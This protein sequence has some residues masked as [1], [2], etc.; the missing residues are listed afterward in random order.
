MLPEQSGPP[1]R[2]AC[3]GMRPW[4]LHWNCETHG[5]SMKVARPRGTENELS[6]DLPTHLLFLGDTRIFQRSPAH[7]CRIVSHPHLGRLYKWCDKRQ[8]FPLIQS[9]TGSRLYAKALF[10]GLHAFVTCNTKF[11]QWR[12]HASPGNKANI[13]Y[14]QAPHWKCA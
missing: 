12:T 11:T 10:P 8:S 5:K 1:V 7:P 6:S 13:R 9:A 4:D 14:M 2:L 3:L